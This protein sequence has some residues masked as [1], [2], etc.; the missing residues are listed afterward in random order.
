MG[1]L[2]KAV[3]MRERATRRD[4]WKEGSFN[5]MRKEGTHQI[6]EPWELVGIG[7]SNLK[8][9]QIVLKNHGILLTGWIMNFSVVALL[10]I[11]QATWPLSLAIPTWNEGPLINTRSRGQGPREISRA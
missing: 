7:V 9:L 5:L 10:T 2:S 1:S 11:F 3:G 4:L 6:K 8:R